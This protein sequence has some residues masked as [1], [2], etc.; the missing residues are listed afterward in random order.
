MDSRPL[1]SLQ[2]KTI[3][4]CDDDFPRPKTAAGVP[5]GCLTDFEC[6]RMDP[7]SSDQLRIALFKTA[8]GPHSIPSRALGAQI[9]A[10]RKHAETLEY[11]KFSQ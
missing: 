5:Q 7:P 3:L 10:I 11:M 9:G 8:T 2:I 4:N 6:W 1:E